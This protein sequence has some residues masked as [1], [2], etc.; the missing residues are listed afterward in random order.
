[1]KKI[2]ILLSLAVLLVLSACGNKEN[3]NNNSNTTT[4][5]EHSNMGEMDHSGSGEVPEGIKEAENPTYKVGDEVVIH[6]DH[7][8][9]MNGAKAKVVGAY[10]TVAYAVTFTPTTGGDP[11]PNHKWVI[12]EEIKDAGSEPLKPGTKVT[13]EADHMEGMMGAEATI[14][15]AEKTTVY[16]VD[17]TPATGGNPVKNHQW[18]V[19]SEL[20]TK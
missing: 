13:L 12:Q 3:N 20:S 19:E 9:G 18:L 16:M 6:A 4:E 7:M 8:E 5:S 11:I 2:L 15:S 14:D 1:M 17:Y 10:D